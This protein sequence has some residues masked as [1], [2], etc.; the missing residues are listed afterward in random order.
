MVYTV[1]YTVIYTDK[2]ILII[3]GNMFIYFN[4]RTYS[5]TNYQHYY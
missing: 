1:I 2:L 5:N 3:F 4:R